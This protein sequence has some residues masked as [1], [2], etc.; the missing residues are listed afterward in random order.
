MSD[1]TIRCR[2]Y[3][4]AVI[5]ARKSPILL[6]KTDF[7]LKQAIQDL[8][9]NDILLQLNVLEIL[10]DLALESYG[11]T[12]I[13]NKGVFNHLLKKIEAIEEDPIGPILIPG[14]MKFF[15][16]V[17]AIHPSKIFK[18][19][20]I[21]INSLFDCL[22]SEDPKLL[23]PGYETLGHL[24]E[25]SD[26]KISLDNTGRIGAVLKNIVDL[27]PSHPSDLKI[28]ALN[29]LESVFLVDPENPNNQIR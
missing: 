19:Y 26:G 6:E 14:L 28:Q 8:Q 16:N 17:A 20:P 22:L 13:E 1:D 11:L 9:T 7:I 4:V 5:L 2:T 29:C 3:N 15:G 27:I 24:A 23:K 25:F 12:Y 10:S 18:D 21:V